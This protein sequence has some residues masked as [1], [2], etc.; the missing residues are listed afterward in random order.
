MNTPAP[1]QSLCALACACLAI[2]ND[3]CAVSPVPVP[4]RLAAARAAESALTISS[5]T[6]TRNLSLAELEAMGMYRVTT[7]TFWPNDDGTYEGPLLSEVLKRAGLENSAG[8][9]IVA[10]DGFSQI[11]PRKDWR[12]WP[13]LLATRR[14]GKL[15]TVRDKGPFRVIYPRDMAPAL[16]DTLY[17]LRWVW[18]VDRIEPATP[19]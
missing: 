7:R 3:A 12:T 16:G 10:L 2:A 14:D 9:R 15:L 5:P 6:G 19:E 4:A 8:I 11:L 17:R 1:L 18:L 13:I